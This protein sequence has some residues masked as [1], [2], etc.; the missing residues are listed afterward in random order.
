M[1]RAIEQVLVWLL[2]A[3]VGCALEANAANV[4]ATLVPGPGCTSDGT[5]RIGATVCIGVSGEHHIETRNGR[6]TNVQL[7]LD[8]V[9]MSSFDAPL[10]VFRGSRLV[11]MFH[12]RRSAN[13]NTSRSEWTKV[14]ERQ[15]SG[16]E[17]PLPLALAIGA[18]PA[19]DIAA[20]GTRFYFTT[21]ARARWTLFVGLLLFG[22]LFWLMKSSNSMLRD[23]PLGP[24]SLGKSQM[25]FWGLLVALS[26]LGVFANTQ[27]LEHVPEQVLVLV[28]IS[29]ATGLGA[30][31]IG[32]GTRSAEIT[33]L[34]EQIA[35]L[36]EDGQQR[37]VLM[38]KVSTL[39]NPQVTKS[40][41]FF[42]D[43]VD[44]GNGPSF[45]RVQALMWTLILG[46]FFVWS[47]S[48][49]VAMPEFSATLLALM[50]ISNAIYLGFKFPEP[51]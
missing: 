29:G 44:D 21:E 8:G 47:I 43:L 50:G 12:V 35:A 18:A 51:S 49:V 23:H 5:V 13:D 4:S 45:H 32:S 20:P 24:Y 3:Y 26:V 10:A 41:G 46:A 34:R 16:Y 17:M 2:V 39:V 11:L 25:A 42:Y 1:Q 14:L 38:E 22:L 37:Q 7:A 6:A 33:R 36:P 19:I 30:I 27:M 40:R 48:Q 28:G 9:L 15:N 31:L